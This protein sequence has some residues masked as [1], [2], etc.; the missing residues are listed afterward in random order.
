M[1]KSKELAL[2]THWRYWCFIFV[3]FYLLLRW[4]R[5]EWEKNEDF[6]DFDFYHIRVKTDGTWMSWKVGKE[7]CGS[8]E[9]N[10]KCR[11]MEGILK[12]NSL[13]FMFHVCLMWFKWYIEVEGP[14][15]L[16]LKLF[17]KY[18]KVALFRKIIIGSFYAHYIPLQLYVNIFAPVCLL[19]NKKKKKI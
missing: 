19:F 13:A 16:K 15:L 14:I 3:V 11:D 12:V 17:L 1:W 2:S 5:C 9:K 10:K 4:L 8:G 18:N 7:K 6:Y